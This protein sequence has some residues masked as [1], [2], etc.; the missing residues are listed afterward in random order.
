V[1]DHPYTGS[2]KPIR[3]G[4]LLAVGILLAVPGSAAGA[5]ADGHLNIDVVDDTR[6]S[7]LV[8]DDTSASKNTV[9][10]TA[11]GE[12]KLSLRDPGVTIS[13]PSWAGPSTGD[14]CTIAIGEIVCRPPPSLRDFFVVLRERSDTVTSDA[15]GAFFGGQGNDR[16]LGGDWLVG[17]PGADEFVGRRSKY[18]AWVDYGQGYRDE[19]SGV[20][21]TLDD[22]AND[23]HPGEGDNVHKSVRNIDGTLGDD[24]FVGS[25]IDNALVGSAGDDDLRGWAGDDHLDGQS[26]NDE[27]RG[28]RGVDFF[29]GGVGDDKVLS[30]DGN[31]ER[32]DCGPGF[33]RVTADS[34]DT[35]ID[36][37]V[38]D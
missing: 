34:V 38:V 21:V 12:R 31:S 6:T 17:G 8:Y 7:T 13:V 27:L 32:V 33:D 10:V 25:G 20:E 3:G 5:T 4:L 9:E 1:R 23:G 26:G 2:V 14:Y 30:R 29:N 18:G 16:L 15:G 22:I 37:E 11:P 24:V 35:L 19:T 28:G 36:C